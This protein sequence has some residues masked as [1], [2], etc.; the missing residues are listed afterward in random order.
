MTGGG[1]FAGAIFQ[2]WSEYLQEASAIFLR[3]PSYNRGIF[4]GGKGVPGM[5]SKSDPRLRTIPFDTRRATFKEVKRVHETLSSLQL[6]ETDSEKEGESA[7]ITVVVYQPGADGEVCLISR[8]SD[9]PPRHSPPPTDQEDSDPTNAPC[10]LETVEETLSTEGLRGLEVW[11]RHKRRRRRKKPAGE[12]EGESCKT[13]DVDSLRSLL[14]HPLPPS[15]AVAP[16]TQTPETAEHTM[17]RSGD[18]T[19]GSESGSRMEGGGESLPDVGQPDVAAM[20]NG[21]LDTAGVTLLHVASAAGQR[22]I[23]RLLMDSGCDPSVRDGKGQPAYAVSA[24][25]ETRN[26]FRKYMADYPEKYDYTR[27][28]VP[29]PLTAEIQSKKAEK[30]RAQKAVKKQKEKEQREE[31][32]RKEGEEDE[33]KRYAAL[34]DREKRALAAEKRFACQLAAGGGTLAH[35][36]RCWLCGVSLLGRIPFEYLDYAFCSTRCLQE[37]RRTGRQ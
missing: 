32:K 16:H 6:Y 4:H 22:S 1:H 10:L 37:H 11:P 34:S 28:Q 9:S 25:K 19:I 5:L 2:G 33:M 27:A 18:V 13:G 8:F 31:R 12:G 20:L 36:R 3:A 29:G 7:A 23:L 17:E 30:K 24:D 15:G 21:K 35:G 26:E 14:T